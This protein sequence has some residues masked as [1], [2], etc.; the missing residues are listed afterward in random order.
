V[1]ARS[2]LSDEEEAQARRSSVEPFQDPVVT[3][4]E[5]ERENEEI[6]EE[7]GG[8]DPDIE[9]VMSYP[10]PKRVGY[11]DLHPER[12]PGGTPSPVR[13]P[14]NAN[15]SDG[16]DDD[17]VPDELVYGTP[18]NTVLP[19]PEDMRPSF[20]SEGSK[21]GPSAS[22]SPTGELDAPEFGEKHNLRF[23]SMTFPQPVLS[24]NDIHKSIPQSK[25]T[26][27]IEMYREKERQSLTSV[28]S[29]LPVPVRSTPASLS[30]SAELAPISPVVRA[31]SPTSAPEDDPPE[32]E[33]E[34][35]SEVD[36]DCHLSP[37]DPEALFSES[38][39]STPGRYVHGAPLHNVLEEEEED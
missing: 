25:T 3:P 27:L 20:E 28:P 10:K 4:L 33:D 38:G 34:A 17:D 6:Q 18:E 11:F 12:R 14:V 15:D 1:R 22:P 5:E 30:K 36:A 29:K 13:L 7:E 32:I 23:E 2:P 21:Y 24:D 39:R 26:L 9:S 8:E 16:D 35:E 19:T 31:S 37:P